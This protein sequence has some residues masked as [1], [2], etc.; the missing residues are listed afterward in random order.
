MNQENLRKVAVAIGW[1]RGTP[2]TPDQRRDMAI[3]IEFDDLIE[4]EDAP[5]V[6]DERVH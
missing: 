5:K 4:Q 2:L 3:A 1:K 6:W